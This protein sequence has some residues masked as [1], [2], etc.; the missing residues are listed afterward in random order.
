MGTLV[1]KKPRRRRSPNVEIS[2]SEVVH[3]PPEAHT[4]DGFLE[5]VF[6]GQAPEKRHV[7]FIDGQVYV[8]MS[9]E[10]IDTHASV[11]TGIYQGL[12]PIMAED[13]F[14]KFFTD[15]VLYVNK[16][17][18]VSC[19][20]DGI[21]ASWGA[22]ESGRVEF[23]VR[24]GKRR[25]LEG[26]ADWLMEIVSDSSVPKDTKVLKAKYHRA[27][28]GEY[29]LI[30][31]RGKDIS[32]QIFHWSKADFVAAPNKDGWVPSKLFGREFRLTREQDRLGSWTYKLEGRQDRH[33]IRAKQ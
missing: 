29:W 24:T 1:A 9:E 32:F 30:D 33:G 22:F 6:S 11:K 3:V 2:H 5:W 20:P 7:T 12:L 15:G 27:E 23:V 13:D 8:D 14:G 18:N 26:S 28:V 4:L 17:A 19:N 10:A 31:A 16:E 21:A 25:A